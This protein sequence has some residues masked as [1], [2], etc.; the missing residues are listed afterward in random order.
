MISFHRNSN[1][2][3]YTL[4]VFFLFFLS[5]PT[6]DEIEIDL[7]R[8]ETPW[9]REASGDRQ[10]LRVWC[11]RSLFLCPLTGSENA[12]HHHTGPFVGSAGELDESPTCKLLWSGCGNQNDWEP[13]GHPFADLLSPSENPLRTPPPRSCRFGGLQAE[14]DE[15]LPNISCNSTE[16]V[17]IF[18]CSNEYYVT[19]VLLGCSLANFA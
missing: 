11:A 15:R 16:S 2:Q 6:F 9:N 18:R 17:G 3:Q 10:G 1:H 19:M 8:P 5:D 4:C 12:R 14:R 13:G 7:I